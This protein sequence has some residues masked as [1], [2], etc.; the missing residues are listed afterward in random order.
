[1]QKACQSHTVTRTPL[2]Y[3]DW[4]E[5]ISNG[6]T[7]FSQPGVMYF[8]A[9]KSR[10]GDVKLHHI[11]SITSRPGDYRTRTRCYQQYRK[12]VIVHLAS[13]VGLTE[14]CTVADDYIRP[15]QNSL[16]LLDYNHPPTHIHDLARTHATNAILLITSQ[17]FY[18]YSNLTIN[19]PSPQ[20][21]AA[22]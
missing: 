5:N 6:H 21:P 17:Q 8:S 10:L 1:M 13:L 12:R 15:G 19:P 11:I 3:L 9:F 2:I 18:T 16:L 7:D 4:F 14:R 22:Y 20:L